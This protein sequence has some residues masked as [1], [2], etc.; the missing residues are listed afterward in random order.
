MR[1]GSAV[2]AERVKGGSGAGE[3]TTH[4]LIDYDTMCVGN[5]DAVFAGEGAE[6][7]EQTIRQTRDKVLSSEADELESRA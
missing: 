7:W 6:Q 3:G 2:G 5:F 4:P 1:N